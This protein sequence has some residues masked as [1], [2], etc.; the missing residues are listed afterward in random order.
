MPYFYAKMYTNTDITLLDFWG[1][2]HK[3]FFLCKF[4]TI[5]YLDLFIMQAENSFILH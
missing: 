3:T 5:T 1:C 4:N 2:I